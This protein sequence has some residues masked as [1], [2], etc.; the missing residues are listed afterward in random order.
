MV[1][2][3]PKY[4][5]KIKLFGTLHL[6]YRFL[7]NSWLFAIAAA[8][9]VENL[10]ALH[11]TTTIQSVSSSQVK[12]QKAYVTKTILLTCLAAAQQLIL[13]FIRI[14]MWYCN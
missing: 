12:K 4:V 14:T 9:Q 5:A 1:L 3:A 6:K 8:Q 2:I 10:A 11:R 7:L 13:L